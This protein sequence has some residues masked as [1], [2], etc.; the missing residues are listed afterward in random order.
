MVQTEG[1][2]NRGEHGGRGKSDIERRE[3]WKPTTRNG[4]FADRSSFWRLNDILE[5]KES[6]KRLIQ[7]NNSRISVFCHLFSIKQFLRY[8]FREPCLPFAVTVGRHFEKLENSSRMRGR[9]FPFYSASSC[10]STDVREPRTA[11]GSR[12]FPLVGVVLLL[13]TDRKGSCWWLWLDVTNAMKWKR[14]KKEKNSI[15]GCRL[16]LKNVC[17]YVG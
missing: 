13:T 8:V 5:G 3:F 1:S 17:A 4:R 15:S 2:E 7:R 10:L 12:M 14:S 9:S 16:W 6:K 11:T